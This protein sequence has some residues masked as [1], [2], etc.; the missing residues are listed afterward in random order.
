MVDMSA[1]NGVYGGEF[2][3]FIMG[4]LLFEK[5]SL[6]AK[7]LKNAVVSFFSIIEFVKI[8]ITVRRSEFSSIASED[9]S[10]SSGI[11]REEIRP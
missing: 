10:E 6:C 5:G 7:M 9:G 1:H 8:V 2:D 11:Q 4:V 3:A